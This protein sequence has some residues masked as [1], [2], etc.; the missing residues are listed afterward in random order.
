MARTMGNGRG[1]RT[2]ICVDL[3]FGQR[4]QYRAMFQYGVE[5]R[6]KKSRDVTVFNFSLPKFFCR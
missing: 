2:D 5:I 6:P 3:I 1:I 4:A